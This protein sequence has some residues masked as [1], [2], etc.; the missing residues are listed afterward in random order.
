MAGLVG[1][2]VGR[3][4]GGPVGR[5]DRGLVGWMLDG[6]V[7]VDDDGDGDGDG[8]GDVGRRKP[9]YSIFASVVYLSAQKIRA[10]HIM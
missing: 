4:V 6:C 1:G 3:W 2:S 9:H 8:A 7:V 10:L 5:W